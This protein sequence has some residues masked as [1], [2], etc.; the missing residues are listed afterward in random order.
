MTCTGHASSGPPRKLKDVGGPL[1]EVGNGLARVLWVVATQRSVCAWG[2]SGS[3]V[4]V[5]VLLEQMAG[6][7][8]ASSRFSDVDH[9][10]GDIRCFSSPLPRALT[11]LLA[12]HIWDAPPVPATGLHANG[13]SDDDETQS[14]LSMVRQRFSRTS[15]GASDGKWRVR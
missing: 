1:G 9:L 10:K 3:V 8:I 12:S 2:I 14:G 13:R 7:V 6:F 5:C 11:R 4:C 15:A